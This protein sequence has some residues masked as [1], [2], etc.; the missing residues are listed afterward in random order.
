GKTNKEQLNV[1]II[2]DC[3]TIAKKLF[4]LISENKFVNVIGQA[5]SVKEGLEMVTQHDLDVVFLDINLPDGTGMEVLVYLKKIKPNVK[6]IV[7]SNSA[8]DLYK[9]KF[10]EK[11]SDYFLDKSTDF[12]K[13]PEIISSIY[14]YLNKAV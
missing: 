11:G 5:K 14:T 7:F 12:T 13:A 6:V 10:A 2:D 1:L 8:N 3:I 9:R 4:E